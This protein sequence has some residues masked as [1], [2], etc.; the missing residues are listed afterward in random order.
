[1]PIEA[2][3]RDVSDGLKT[4]ETCRF[5]I[6]LSQKLDGSSMRYRL[7]DCRRGS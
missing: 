3:P 6:Q 2:L 1:M 5:E 4:N 7:F